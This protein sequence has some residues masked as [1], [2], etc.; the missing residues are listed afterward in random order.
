[1]LGMFL[2]IEMFI[3]IGV[4]LFPM[5]VV[6]AL[7]TLPVEW[8][9]SYRAKTAMVEAGLLSSSE[10]RGASAVLNAIFLTLSG[11]CVDQHTGTVAYHLFG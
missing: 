4:V 6:F 8:D 2:S 7:V 10:K 3:L 1:M 5:R 11:G 9:A